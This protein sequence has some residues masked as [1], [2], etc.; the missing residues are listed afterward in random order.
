M[1][2]LPFV[3]KLEKDG[4]IS[5]AVGTMH[6]YSEDCTDALRELSDKVEQFCFELDLLSL[7]TQ[8][9]LRL[10]QKQQELYAMPMKPILALLTPEERKIYRESY[11]FSEEELANLTLGGVFQKGLEHEGYDPM[12]GLD[13]TLMRLA[14]EKPRHSLET[15][16]EQSGVIETIKGI[17][18]EQHAQALRKLIE[19]SGSA[20]ND[21]DVNDAYKNGDADRLLNC[22]EMT[23]IGQIKEQFMYARNQRMA[24]RALEHLNRPS[25]IAAGTYHLIGERSILEYLRG[26]GVKIERIQPK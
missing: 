15:L 18:P 20:D 8:E 23:A 13:I 12:K 4:I 5:Y 25:I 19:S 3:W 21:K 16:E 22:L 9:Q 17:I 11:G 26:E 14:Q 24:A 2:E 7:S 1:N 10:M 6:A